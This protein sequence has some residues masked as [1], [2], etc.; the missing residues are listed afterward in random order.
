[1]NPVSE[2]PGT[3]QTVP[4]E[5][6]RVEARTFLRIPLHRVLSET[7]DS[8]ALRGVGRKCDSVLKRGGP[9]GAKTGRFLRQLGHIKNGLRGIESLVSVVKKLF[10]DCSRRRWR[11]DATERLAH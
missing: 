9:E 2:D 10:T 4:R 3:V 6:L 11:A 5:C 1:M 7:L 8:D